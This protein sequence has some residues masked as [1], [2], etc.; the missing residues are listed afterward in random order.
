MR[1]KIHSYLGFAQKSGNMLSGYNT[2]EMAISRHKARLIL[3][4]SDVGENTRK[5]FI[6]LARDAGIPVYVYGDSSE[7]PV[8][9]GNEGKGVFGITD[10]HFASIIEKKIVEEMKE[11]SNMQDIK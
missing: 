4:T 8:Y 5:K 10:S 11:E 1:K 7:V 6:K 2:C 9:T 3:L